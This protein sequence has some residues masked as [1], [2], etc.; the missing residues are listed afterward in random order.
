[1]K[2]LTKPIT[3][4]LTIYS[5]FINILRD[6]NASAA[7]IEAVEFKLIKHLQIRE[8]GISGLVNSICN[9]YKELIRHNVETQYLAY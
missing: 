5:G 3:V 1:M 4:F 2:N 6:S 8:T 7:I 9:D